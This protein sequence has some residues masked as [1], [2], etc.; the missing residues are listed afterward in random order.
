MQH[1]DSRFKR[2]L[3]CTDFSPSADFAFE[4]ALDATLRRP[5]AQLY[6][7]HV[8]PETDAQFW[9]SYI[10]EVD[11][12]DAQARHDIHAKIKETYLSR[13][14]ADLEVKV[15]LRLGQAAGKIIEVVQ[16][17]QID[18]VVIG[19]EGSGGLQQALFGK[20]AEK[21]VRKSPCPVMVIPHLYQKSDHS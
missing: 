19:R 8:I 11:K 9:K 13:V 4:F 15:E 14:P 1:P 21:I 2:I 5:G 16:A 7:L 6:L 12:V 3:F 10:Y 20:V 18:L 17:K